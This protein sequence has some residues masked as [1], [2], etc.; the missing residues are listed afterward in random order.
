MQRPNI[1]LI[2]VDDMGYGD[3]GVFNEDSKTPHLDRLVG[4]PFRALPARGH[5]WKNTFDMPSIIAY[6]RPSRYG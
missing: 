6:N 3:F 4:R 2:L 1:V 5:F